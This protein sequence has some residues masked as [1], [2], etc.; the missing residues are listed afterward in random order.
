MHLERR[1]AEAD[2]HS[3]GQ[4]SPYDI[5]VVRSL[6]NSTDKML[7]TVAGRTPM[8]NK[9]QGQVA[10]AMVVDMV[11]LPHS[12]EDMGEGIIRSNNSNMEGVSHRTEINI[13]NNNSIKVRRHV[14]LA[15]GRML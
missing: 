7:D 5:A 3:T 2:I 9:I 11:T 8:T 15:N 13:T 10:M 1:A 4:S 12:K 6:G 14:N